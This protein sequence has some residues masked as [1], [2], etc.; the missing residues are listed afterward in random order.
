M[1]IKNGKFFDS[2]QCLAKIDSGKSC[3]CVAEELGVGK[4]QIQNNVKNREDFKRRWETSK[5]K[6]K[7]YIDQ[8]DRL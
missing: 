3:H 4:T 5:H 7:E 8:E 2:V 6:E 1:S